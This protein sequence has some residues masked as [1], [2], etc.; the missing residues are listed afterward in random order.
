MTRDLTQKRP[1][2]SWALGEGPLW[3]HSQAGDLLVLLT[4]LC[5][6]LEKLNTVFKITQL[7]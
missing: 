1:R 2:A 7:V 4:V 5:V 3:E 6:G